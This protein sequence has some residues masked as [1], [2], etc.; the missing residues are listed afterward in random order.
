MNEEPVGVTQDPEEMLAPQGTVVTVRGVLDGDT[1][2][3]RPAVEGETRVDL[4]GLDAPE[5]A[6][7]N[8]GAQPFGQ[9]AANFVASQIEDRK[10]ALEFDEA[11]V[12]GSGRLMAYVRLP[13]GT[14]FNR[15]LVRQGYAQAVSSGP[16]ARHRD[17]LLDAQRD[18][19]AEELGLWGLPPGQLC[20]L[21][22]RDNGVGG[23]CENVPADRE[24][25]PGPEDEAPV[26]GVPPLPPDGDYDCGHFASQEQAQKVFDAEPGD[27]HELDEEGNGVACEWLP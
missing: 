7:A 18:A 14:L 22:D 27:P 13:G 4:I 12:D 6:G 16:N 23:G 17:E 5:T 21:T 1:I 3:V 24:Q 11:M 15:E 9:A 26:T 19:R 20:R 25:R 2:E 8:G 10:V